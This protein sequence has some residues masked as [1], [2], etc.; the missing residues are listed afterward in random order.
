MYFKFPLYL[1]VIIKLI[2]DI[3]QSKWQILFTLR[4]IF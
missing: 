2:F 4:N 3:L 1:K